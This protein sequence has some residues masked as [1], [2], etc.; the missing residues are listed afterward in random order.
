MGLPKPFDTFRLEKQPGE[1]KD[2][3]VAA[4]DPYPLKGVIYPT[5][6]GDIE[7][8]TGEDGHPLDVFVGTG[9]IL[10]FFQVFR[11]EIAEQIEHKFY[12]NLTEDEE[13]AVLEAFDPV[14]RSHGRFGSIDELIKAMSPFKNES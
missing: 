7:G 10:G 11:P 5:N 14:L 6:Y 4:D 3:H 1:Y 2:F 12:L 8:Y 9:V 13:A